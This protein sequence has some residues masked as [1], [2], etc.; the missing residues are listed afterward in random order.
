MT[1]KSKSP[2]K[3]L[4]LRCLWLVEV[5]RLP[6]AEPVCFKRIISTPRFKIW[7]DHPIRPATT[8]IASIYLSRW[9]KWEPWRVFQLGVLFYLK[10]IRLYICMITGYF[11]IFY[12]F[13]QQWLLCP[14]VT[15]LTF[16]LRRCVMIYC[17]E[18]YQPWLRSDDA[19]L[20][21]TKKIW[22]TKSSCSLRAISNVSTWSNRESI[23]TNGRGETVIIA[24]SLLSHHNHLKGK[25]YKK[26]N[27]SWLW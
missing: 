6:D 7:I 17:D 11:R 19:N 2:T 1:F 20:V 23:P 5:C 8:S 16:N 24:D 4:F 13:P 12:L 15:C 25:K 3:C 26:R 9:H 18:N 22:S 14:L 21:L 27:T 10:F